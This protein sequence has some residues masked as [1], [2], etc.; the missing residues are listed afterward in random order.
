MSLRTKV[1]H[2]G[3]YLFVRQALSIVIGSLGII[4]LTRTIGPGAYG[5]YGGALGI[6]TYLLNLSQ[7]GIPVYLIRREG[8]LQ[9]QDYHQAFSL[10]LLLGLTGA[11]S[12]AALL[13]LLEHWIRLEGFG[14]VA[15]ALFAGLPLFLLNTVP[16]AR[17][18]RALDYRRIAIIDLSSQIATYGVAVPLAFKGLGP[19]APVGGWWAGQLLRLGLLYW[20]TA[21]RPRLHWEFARVRAMVGYG[22]GYSASIWVWQLRLLVNPLIVG[23]YAGA[24]AVGYVALA[25]RLVEQLSFAKE[26]GWRL[27]IAVLARVQENK[28]RLVRAV[29]E[30]MTLQVMTLGPFLVGFGLVAPWIIPL[31]LGSRWLPFLEIYPFIALGY[32]SN[33]MFN[34]Q[35]SA[36]YVLRRNWEV[37]LFTLVH[38]VLFAGSASLLVS[39]LGLRGYGWAEVGALPSYLVL[40]SWFAAYIGMPGYARAGTWFMAF[41]V[42]LFGWQVGPWAW[43]SLLVP[44]ILPATRKELLQLIATVGRTLAKSNR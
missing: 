4:L 20:V 43:A 16:V 29:N 27:S 36:L 8:E 15:L 7:L 34:L 31:L 13:P 10:L 11:G 24:D 2:G 33:A 40:H 32:L 14:P 3:A 18:E 5:L 30:G 19:W 12:A 26:I 37:A 23:R 41:A 9:T 42:A 28:A 44:L 21:Y 17:L 6:Y 1:L 38:I 35:S 22:L 25:I 39:R